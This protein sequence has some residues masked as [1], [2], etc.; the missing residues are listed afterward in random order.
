MTWYYIKLKIHQKLII[1]IQAKQ[2]GRQQIYLD[3]VFRLKSNFSTKITT[4]PRLHHS[5]GGMKF[6]TQISPILNLSNMIT[7]FASRI[8]HSIL[9]HKFCP[10]HFLLKF[11]CLD[12]FWTGTRLVLKLSMFLTTSTCVTIQEWASTNETEPQPFFLNHNNCSFL[13]K[14]GIFLISLAY[15]VAWEKPFV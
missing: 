8:Y 11:Y 4:L 7:T 1:Q 3:S 15:L 10:K 13:G 5:Q 6:A 2:V 9:P 12:V 14:R